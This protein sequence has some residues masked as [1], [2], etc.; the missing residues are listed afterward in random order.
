M[1]VSVGVA[2]LKQEIDKVEEVLGSLRGIIP[3]SET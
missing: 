3:F 2:M 1:G